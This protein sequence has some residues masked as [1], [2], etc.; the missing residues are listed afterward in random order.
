MFSNFATPKK[1]VGLHSHSTFST[2]DGLGYPHEHI[3]FVLQNGMNAWALTDHGNANGLAHARSHTAKL[4]KKGVEFRQLYGVECYFVPSLKDWSSDYAAHKQAIKDAKSSNEAEKLAKKKID[5]D[6]DDDAD[7]GG[8]VIEDENET[9]SLNIMDDE[10]KRRYHLVVVARNRKGLANL[11]TMVKKSYKEGFYRY[12]RIDFDMLK[13]FGSDLIVS[14]ACL[15]GIYSNRILR[16]VAHGQSRDQIQNELKNLTDRF[17]QY[18][19]EGFHLELQFNKLEKQHVVNDYLLEHHKLT[20]IPL[21]ATCDSHYPTPDKWL[22]REMYKQLGWIGSNNANELPKF[23]DLK[24]ELYPKNAD[25]MWQ[26]FQQAWNEFD[27]YKGNESLVKEAIERTSDIAWEMCD[28]TWIDTKVKL[29]VTDLPNRT[30]MQQLTD[31]VKDALVKEGLADNQVYVDRAKEELSDIKYLGHEAYFLTMYKIFKEAENHTFLGP[32]RGSGAGSLVNYLLGIT[33]LDPIPYNLLWNRFLGRHRVNWPD[34]DTDAGNRDELIKAAQKLFGDEAV[35]PV[36]NFN[37]LKLKS[38]VKDISKFYNVPFEEVNAVTGPLQ[39]EV[40]YHAMDESMEK[41]V[42]VLKHEDC[43]A[44]SAKYK[45]FMEKYPQVEEHIRTL[46]A[47]NKSIGRHAG[48]VIVADP[49]ELEETLPMVGVRGELQTPWAEGLNFR[50]LEDN[51]F[52]K[53]DFLGLTLLRDVENCIRRI[54]KRENKR[55][56]SF[57]EI[58]AFFDKYLNCRFVKQDDPMVWKH[59]YEDG[60]FTGIF[61]FAQRGARNF[62]MEAKPQNIEDLAAVTAIYRPGP[63][64]ANVHKKYVK[65]KNDSFIRK[66]EYSHPVIEEVLGPT[67]GFIAFQEQFM[68]LAQKLAGFSPAEGDKLRKT[69]VKKSVEKLDAIY[70][71]R[72][73]AREKFIKGAKAVSGVATESAIS[74]W[75]EIDFFAQYGF[76]KSHAVAYAIDSYYSAWLHTHYETDWLSTILESEKGSPDGMGK[77]IKEIK[78][79]GYKF[80]S[81]DINYSGNDWYYSDELKAFVPPLSSIKGTGDKAVDEIMLNRPYKNLDDLL[82][83][84]EGEWKHSK[85]NKASFNA[86]CKMEAFGSLEEMKKGLVVN[87]KQLYK[88]IIDNY[89]T[90]H[91][92]RYGITD[93][94]KRKLEK[95]GQVPQ[96]IIEKLLQEILQDDTD[97]TRIEKINNQFELSSDVQEDLL[98]PSEMISKL[99]Q[100]EIPS[101]LTLPEC[102]KVI[103]WFCVLNDF[104]VKKTKNGKDFITAT[105]ADNEGNTNKIK[106]WG[107]LDTKDLAYTLWLGEVSMQTDWGLSTNAG[108]MRR[109]TAFE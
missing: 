9:K 71:E 96:L 102:S 75:E 91:R 79:Y 68:L 46:F 66:P 40:I 1:F 18:I 105:I 69:L 23:E 53:F 8:L 19:G 45:E 92:G 65:A 38:L 103:A 104:K 2:Y 22:A 36:S 57:N 44:Y 59:V 86:L 73:D 7:A 78:S 4:Q 50:N 6:A 14:T 74:L 28:D 97:W 64:K 88:L 98:Y 94:A 17:H 109:L 26:E 61:Q 48:G 95:A 30:T 31:L 35:V 80:S 81:I 99:E 52:L 70:K 49:K 21:I 27:F 24:C 39:E 32:G 107:S 93:A 84:K 76:N 62:A 47:Q 16:G 89:D 108:K 82:F 51:G 25:Q 5:I 60:H 15:G 11:F 20:G 67:Y 87:H 85:M 90:L 43:M 72:Q 33:Q 55:E 29:P 10:W 106:I 58:K 42:F 100:K 83:N 77:A 13:E 101:A 56:P 54:L 12:P 3:D 63:L 41:S 37:T 34:I